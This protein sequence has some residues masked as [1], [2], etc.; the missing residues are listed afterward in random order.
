MHITKVNEAV[1]F[2]VTRQASAGLKLNIIP[3][4]IGPQLS[5]ESGKT[6]KVCLLFDFRKP[7][8]THPGNASCGS[9]EVVDRVEAVD[10]VGALSSNLNSNCARRPSK[11]RNPFG[12]WGK[13]Y[14]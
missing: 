2:I 14:E 7:P 10:R 3:I 8:P 5:N 12:C 13:R 1:S 4:A 11:P 9:V 6:Q